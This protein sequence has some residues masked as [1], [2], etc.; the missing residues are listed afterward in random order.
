M[1]RFMP[2]IEGAPRYPA[3]KIVNGQR[4]ARGQFP[5]QAAIF[6]DNV[7]FCGGSLISASWILCAAHCTVR[8]STFSVH[9]GAQN[10]NVAEAGRV[11]MVS[12]S[13]VNHAAYNPGNLHNDISLVRLPAPVSL[14]GFIQL[15]SLPPRSLASNSFVGQPVQVSGWGR[16]SDV[17]GGISPQLN[18]VTTSVIGNAQCAQT[19]GGSVIASTICASGAGGRSPCQGDSGGPL[20]ISAGG[21]YLQI[22]VVS[23]VSSFGCASGSPSGY[24]RVTAFLGWISANTGIPVPG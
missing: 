8:I 24:A 11:G 14:S 9:L 19:Y 6:L 22:G 13:A 12:R 5:H 17:S 18:F 3:A 2:E 20:V 10:L 4:A 16:M 21:A 23:F 7:S 15:V 1:D